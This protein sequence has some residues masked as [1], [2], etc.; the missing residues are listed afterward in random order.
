MKRK[1]SPALVIGALIFVVYTITNRFIAKI[2][3]WAALPAVLAAIILI[4]TEMRRRGKS[5]PPQ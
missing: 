2:P 1:L 3:D 4:I 5:A